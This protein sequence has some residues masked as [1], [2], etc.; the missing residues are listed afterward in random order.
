MQEGKLD[1]IGTLS[2]QMENRSKATTTKCLRTAYYI[3]KNNRPYTD[4]ETLIDLQET[5]GVDLGRNLHSHDTCTR[6]IEV[7]SST[8]RR[9]L[10]E[11]IR[12]SKNGISLIIDESTSLSKRSCLIIYMRSKITPEDPPLNVFLDLV[13]LPAQNA[14]TVLNCLMTSLKANGFDDAYLSSHLISLCTDGASVMLGKQSGVGAQLKKQFPS[15]ALWHCLNHRLELSV[16]DSIKAVDGIF[17]I[18]SM[19]SKLHNIYS[20][21]SKMQR[22]LNDVARNLHVHLK[23]IGKVFDVRWVASS[24]RTA[25]A[26]WSDYGALV[27]HFNELSRDD[28]VK[29]NERYTYSGIVSKLTTKEFIQDLA[30]VKDCLTALAELSETLQNRTMTINMANKH[31]KWTISALKSMQ[32]GVANGQYAFDKIQENLSVEAEGEHKVTFM[33]VDLKEF[34]RRTQYQSFSH[35]RFIQVLIDNVSARLSIETQ[36]PCLKLIDVLYPENWPEDYDIPWLEGENTIRHLCERFFIPQEGIIPSFREYMS[37]PMKV[38]GQIQKSMIYGLAMM[39]PVSSSEAER[40]FSQMN[41]VSTSSRS[42]LTIQN[43]SSLLFIGVNGPPSHLWD[44]V[45]SL[46]E[47]SKRHYHATDNLSRKRIAVMEKDLTSVEKVFIKT[48]AT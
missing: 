48:T 44:P 29:S 11:K 45:P 9:Q 5:N 17:H 16:S 21:S 25:N 28:I 13:E 46:A 24:Y 6:M 8:M 40:G 12:G 31:I 37:N 23:K 20:Y 41:L 3:A 15:I 30:L 7:I 14:S 33:G 39:I 42:V 36:E 10:C 22:Q 2:A 34:T 18:Q 26:I 1:Q 35:G 4:Y 43:V 47:W 27:K 38:P 19:L 32:S